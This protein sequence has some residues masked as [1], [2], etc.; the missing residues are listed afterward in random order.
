MTEREFAQNMD[1]GRHQHAR[2]QFVDRFASAFRTETLIGLK[3]STQG[4]LVSLAVI[5]VLLLYLVPLPAVY[6]FETILVLFALLG[7]AHYV[8]SR[9]TFGIPWLSYVFIALDFALLTYALFVPNPFDDR[10]APPQVAFRNDQIVYYFLLIA[11][12]AFSYSPKL[13]LWAGLTAALGW[14]AG[15][16]WLLSLP[17]THTPFY[18]PP[19]MTPD[20]HLASHL[21]AHFVDTNVGLQN[22]VLLLLVAGILVVVVR[23]SRRLVIRQAEIAHE[24]A[25]L[26]R[27]FSPNVLDEVVEAVG[28]LTAVRK[29]EVAILFADIVGFTQLCE[30][31]PPENVMEL[32]RE[33]HSRLEEEVFRFDG[34]L[35]K[36]I[37]D[38][39]MASFGAPKPGPQDGTNGLR[40]ARAMIQSM[41]EWNHLREGIG[42]A[43]I[44]IGIGLHYGLAVMGDVG[45]ERCAAFAVIGDTTNTTSRLQ[46][47]TR[48]LGAD[49]VVSQTLLE[50]VRRETPETDQELEG[51]R[52]A[53]KQPIRGR[54]KAMHV[55][56]LPIPNLCR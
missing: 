39:V 47:L 52:D 5:A 24:R 4:R 3:W 13:M 18:H 11:A 32:L 36:F 9:S 44:Q 20:Q 17:A 40:C 42:E 28:P 43:P 23:R 56:V 55:W 53:G 30:T 22:L 7:I 45:S 15:V 8:L 38:A 12:M 14:V 41:A 35:D 33:Y 54:Q 34:T 50:A 27:Y 1:T 21:D 25:A 51:F 2:S 49:I 31:M 10:Q 19:A 37:G 16:L 46:S 6:Y 26:A 48:D 29:H